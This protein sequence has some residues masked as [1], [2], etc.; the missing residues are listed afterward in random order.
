MEKWLSPDKRIRLY[1]GDCLEVMP[2]WPSGAVDA[3]VTD[4]P[5]GV[6]FRSNMRQV[7]EKFDPLENDDAPF[8]EWMP[9][10]YRIT[11]D[12]GCAL[13]CYRWDV[14]DAFVSAFGAAGWAVKSQAVWWKPG[15]SMGDLKS[16]FAT[17]HELML[18]ATKGEFQFPRKRPMSVFKVSKVPPEQMVHPTEKPVGLMRQLLKAV[19]RPKGAVADPCMGS[20]TTAVAC[21]QLGMRFLGVEKDEKYFRIAVSKIEEELV[22]K[23]S[24]FGVE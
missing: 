8:T 9:E 23:S 24:K 21:V 13:C 12:T 1:R 19:V 16:T 3:I 11:K 10:A 7:T 14:Q 4:P 15:G 6:Q 5:Y 17:E 18:F 2:R 20:G 22:D